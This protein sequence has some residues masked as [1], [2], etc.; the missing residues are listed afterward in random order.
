MASRVSYRY[1]LLHHTNEDLIPPIPEQK[2][3]APSRVMSRIEPDNRLS[4]LEHPRAPLLNFHDPTKVIR[5]VFIYHTHPRRHLTP[6]D[7]HQ[8]H[9]HTGEYKIGASGFTPSYCSSGTTSAHSC[10]SAKSRMVG[11]SSWSGTGAGVDMAVVSYVLYGCQRWLR[12]S[13]WL[14]QRTKREFMNNGH[15]LS[16][17]IPEGQDRGI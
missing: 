7:R 13:E 15:P 12:Y 9:S 2:Q 16:F 10:R 8:E 6:Q 5:R 3:N 11:S 17:R 1:C 4:K 14:S